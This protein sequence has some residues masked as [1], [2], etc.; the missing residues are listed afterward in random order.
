MK[1]KKMKMKEK[2]NKYLQIFIKKLKF[3]ENMKK[4]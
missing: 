2:K 1:I 3:I 4:K